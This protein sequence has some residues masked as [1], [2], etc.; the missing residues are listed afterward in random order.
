MEKVVISVLGRDRPGIVAAVSGIL[1]DLACNIESVSQT[2][3]QGEFAG[4][5]IASMPSGISRED[6]GK[7]LDEGLRPLGLNVL[8]KPLEA[9]PDTGPALPSEPFVITTTGPDRLG[10]VASVTAVLARFGVNITNLKA[11]FKGGDLP[12]RN[13]MIYEVDIPAGIDQLAF[14]R[15]LREKAEELG[16]DLS[17]QHRDIFEAVHRI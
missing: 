8:L 12:S 7:R 11:V 14:R 6:L 3:L 9:A 5:F 15:T 16:L 2:I 10:L 1:F 17:L 13:V 4:I